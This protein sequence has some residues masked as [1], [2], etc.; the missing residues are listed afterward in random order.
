MIPPV[1]VQFNPILS[2]VLVS[3]WPG[4]TSCASPWARGWRSDAGR[5]LSLPW[6]YWASHRAASPMDRQPAEED[7]IDRLHT[8]A[9]FG[10]AVLIISIC[11]VPVLLLL[12]K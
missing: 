10:G 4:R 6:L 11:V 1:P 7:A 8:V 3:P 2:T 12:R 5:S 9:S